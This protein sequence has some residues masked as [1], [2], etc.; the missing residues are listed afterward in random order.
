MRLRSYLAHTYFSID[1]RTL[2][3]FRISLGVILLIDLFFRSRVYEHFYSNEG[4][5]PNHTLLWAPPAPHLFSLFFTLS[6][7]TEVAV[8]MALCGLVFLSLLVGYRTKLSQILAFICLVSL[9]T[10]VSPLENGGDMVMNILTTFTMFL[11]LGKRFSVDAVIASM[12][13][14]VEH[15]PSDLDDRTEMRLPTA[16]VVS[17]VVFALILQLTLIYFFNVVHKT[18]RT[19]EDG[20]AVHLTLQQDRIITPFGVWLREHAPLWALK[21]MTWS[22]IVIESL[23]AFLVISPFFPVWTRGLALALMPFLHLSFA[24]CLNLGPFSYAMALFFMLLWHERHL[25][26]VYRFVQRRTQ[27]RIVY[28]D[29]DCGICFWIARLL[30][31]LDVLRRLELRSN[32]E[33]LPEG[34]A[35]GREHDTLIVLNRDSGRVYERAAAVSQTL[36]ALPMGFLIAWLLRL[37]GLH[38]IFNALY[39]LV[40]GNRAR[41]S[42]WVGLNACGLPRPGG[43]VE[44]HIEAPS[45]ARQLVSRTAVALREL[46]ALVLI[47]ACAGE[48]LNANSAVPKELRFRQNEELRAILDYVRLYQGWRMFAP[49]A[50][51]H[52][53]HISVEATTVDGRLVDPYNQVASRVWNVPLTAIPNRLANDQYFTTYSLFIPEGRFRP[54]ITP[55][56]QWIMRY[57]LRTGNPKDRITKFVAYK[58]VDESPP[59]GQKGT[60]N[61]KKVEFLRFPLKR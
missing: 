4:L 18:G 22:T 44:L 11:P 21:G 9:N 7:P 49:E 38:L 29:A 27:R 24:L 20:T 15:Q 19:W 32:Q 37:P 42:A 34:V 17:I 2:V 25:A 58:L 60:R 13:R 48:L 10:R 41:I 55:F 33:G 40:A 53:I 57:H 12:R 51:A 23:G 31:R 30:A 8:A 56:E 3:L 54:Y 16:R 47:V 5:L 46:S 6:T 36:Q 39:D 35:L 14:R 61:F 59:F 43:A 45:S 26:F 1:P 28:Y 50:P 52:D